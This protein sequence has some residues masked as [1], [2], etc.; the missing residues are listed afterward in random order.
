MRRRAFIAGIGSAAAWPMMARAQQPR[1]PVI[2]RINMGAASQ[3]DVTRASLVRGLNE[4]GFLVGQNV[5]IEQR[6]ADGQV[7]RLPAL[8]ANL[9]QRKVDLI[10]GNTAVAVAAKA[11]TST[12]PIVF[13]TAADPVANGLVA[14]FNHP[15]GNVTGVHLRAGDEATA[16]LIEVVHELLPEATTIGMLINPQYLDSG[17]RTAAV[18]AAVNSLRLKVVV[19]EATTETDIEPA[20]SKLV[21]AQVGALLIGDNI[22]FVS[23]RDRIASIAMRDRLPIFGSPSVASN[24]LASYGADDYDGLRQAGIYVGRI[25]KG[26][27]PRDLPVLQPTKF[28]LVINLKTAKALGLTVPPSLLA[29][30]DEVIE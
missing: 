14:S 21:E 15:G 29:R 27:K 5:A 22:Y 2:G 7:D 9:L 3:P 18:Q 23:L 16:K 11:A 1:M 25:L 13:V 4:T 20:I 17:L 30:A 12:I 26:E 19:A 10:L 24:A 6:G 8:V 28:E